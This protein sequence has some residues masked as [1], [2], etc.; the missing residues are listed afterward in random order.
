[1]KRVREA[2]IPLSGKGV[3]L[4]VNSK[5]KGW[6]SRKA[7]TEI[8]TLPG[9]LPTVRRTDTCHRD[10]GLAFPK[11]EIRLPGYGCANL[12]KSDAQECDG[13]HASLFRFHTIFCSLKK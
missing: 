10:F 5:A 2:L 9:F 3:V 8:S 11:A 6:A 13:D 1:M 7:S 4:G 12:E